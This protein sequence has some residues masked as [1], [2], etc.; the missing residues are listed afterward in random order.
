MNKNQKQIFDSVLSAVKLP[1]ES[2]NVTIH[3]TPAFLKELISISDFI[4]WV[5]AS[6]GVVVDQLGQARG[7]KKQNIEV[8][9]IS[10]F[11]QRCCV[12]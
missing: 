4:S 1:L 5:V 2:N 7:I 3:Q 11:C 8:D 6:L 12:W 10:T 9:R